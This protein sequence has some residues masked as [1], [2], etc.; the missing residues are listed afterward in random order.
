M[1]A[2]VRRILLAPNAGPA[3]GGGHV[4]RC[5]S[6]ATALARK[7]VEI[8][9][10]APEPAPRLV[11]RFAEIPV[12]IL[13][14]PDFSA[15]VQ[16]A[17]AL[18]PDAVVLDHYGWG[19]AEEA[20]LAPSSRCVMVLDDL[21]DRPHG[22]DLLLDPGYGRKRSDYAGRLRPQARL[23]LGPEYALL[24]PAFA[25]RRAA[26]FAPVR[27]QVER[28]F[29]SFGLSDVEGVAARAVALIRRVLPGAQLDVALA[30]DAFSLPELR[31]GADK[32]SALHLHVDEREVAALIAAADLA[33]GAGG[34]ATWERCCLGAPTVAVVVAE[35]QRGLIEALDGVGALVG[36]ALGA[37][38]FDN[39]FEAALR[40][41]REPS[42]R[43]QLRDASRELCDGRGAERAAA[44]LFSVLD[45][46]G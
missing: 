29:V 27:A 2:G 17:E 6:L 14:A 4:L 5:L 19:A 15:V 46:Q 1:R 13:L 45:E 3:V 7:G 38:D 12:K 33:V 28:V 20:E 24:R 23:L 44:A 31:V 40:R 10:A 8:V 25:A 21:A 42:F 41:V 37:G 36:C 22:C 34:S 32:D 26:A 35:N 9:V 30:A 43:A 18:R 11:E 16:A 39:A